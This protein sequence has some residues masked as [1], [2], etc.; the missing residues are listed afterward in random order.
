MLVLT[1]LTAA[2]GAVVLLAQALS[3]RAAAEG[4][5]RAGGGLPLVADRG[6]R[7]GDASRAERA[8]VRGGLRVVPAPDAAAD[9]PVATTAAPA[10]AHAA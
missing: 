2:A 6:A 10:A 8:A 5:E 1:S 9:G 7:F 3:T 4:R